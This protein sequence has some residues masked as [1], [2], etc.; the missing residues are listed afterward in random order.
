LPISTG[1]PCANPIVKLVYERYN[2]EVREE[3]VLVSRCGARIPIQLTGASINDRENHIIGSV[4]VFRDV[5]ASHSMARQ[6]TW[7]A[8]HDALTSLAN[9]REFARCLSE[10]VDT[11]DKE[12]REHGILYMDLDQFKVVNDTCG[13]LAGDELLRQLSALLRHRV[14]ASD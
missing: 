7:Q 13:H 1:H 5:S 10:L 4:L 3:A 11:A 8:T 9:R 14:R 12:D 2:K 6:L